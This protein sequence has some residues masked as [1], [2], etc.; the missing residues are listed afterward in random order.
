MVCEN[1]C[2]R[3]W[4]SLVRIDMLQARNIVAYMKYTPITMSIPIIIIKH[5]ILPEIEE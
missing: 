1:L 3:F 5:D 2:E 4:E